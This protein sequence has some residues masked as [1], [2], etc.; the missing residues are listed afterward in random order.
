MWLV[1]INVVVYV[2]IADEHDI[3]YAHSFTYILSLNI[4]NSVC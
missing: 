1:V 4:Y 3:S 2:V